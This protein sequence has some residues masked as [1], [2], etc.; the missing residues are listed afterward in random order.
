M[1]GFKD[2]QKC[3]NHGN[4]SYGITAAASNADTNCMK[5]VQEVTRHTSI[6]SHF[7][8]HRVNPKKEQGYQNAIAGVSTDGPK[9]QSGMSTPLVATLSSSSKCSNKDVELLR[10]Y[11]NKENIA[12]RKTHEAQEQVNTDITTAPAPDSCFPQESVN[13]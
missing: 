12:H 4:H 9:Q 7:H 11:D 2:W 1:C 13:C 3:T 10:A 6:M 5:Y 8:Y